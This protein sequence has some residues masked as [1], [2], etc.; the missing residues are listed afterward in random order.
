MEARRALF[1]FVA[2]VVF[3]STLSAQNL[4]Q[5]QSK[6]F[7][8]SATDEVL[9]RQVAHQAERYRK[10]LAVEWLGHEL[11]DWNQKCPIR[12][13]LA[14]QS[15][16]ETTFAF[17]GPPGA[18][19]PVEWSMKIF[20]PANRLL[21]AVLP[22]EVTHTIFATHFGRPLPRW[23]DEG[24]CTTVEHESERKKIQALLLE[25]LSARPSKGIPFNQL[26][27][28][29]Q[30]PDEMLPLYAQ[31]YSLARFLILQ[32]GRRH[33]VHFVES[34]LARCPEI[35]TPQA[36]DAAVEEYYGFQDLSELQVSWVKW[37]KDGSPESIASTAVAANRKPED[38]Q[39]FAVRSA[40]QFVTAPADVEQKTWYHQQMQFGDERP[41]PVR[42]TRNDDNTVIS[43]DQCDLIQGR[44]SSRP[45]PTDA[46]TFWR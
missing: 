22:H 3:G 20:G 1:V 39:K 6:N 24:A 23:A 16:G 29:M 40:N 30:Y 45:T 46:Q 32:K 15:G 31:G 34:G 13:E 41:T 2:L 19:Q 4:Y 21:D 14:A 44:P 12:V 25:Y 42:P 5:V 11:P 35:M 33:F 18:S 27:Q 7:V 38:G 37:V 43:A 28:L 36:W 26:F 10:E 9:A 17:V 8:V